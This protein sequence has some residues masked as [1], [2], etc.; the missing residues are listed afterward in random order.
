MKKPRRNHSATFKARIAK[1]AIRG[2]KT[3][4][5][6]ARENNLHPSQV[7]NWKK[8]LEENM[9]LLFERKNGVDDEKR[10]LEKQCARLERKVGQLVIE[11]EWL[12]K[13]CDELG[14]E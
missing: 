9:A 8:E 11:K 10:G 6:I 5:E 12:E 7:T 13:K 1:E 4:A 3:V 2:V 14:I